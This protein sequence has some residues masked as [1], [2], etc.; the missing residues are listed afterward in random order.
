VMLG[1][2]HGGGGGQRNALVGGTDRG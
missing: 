1:E 2:R